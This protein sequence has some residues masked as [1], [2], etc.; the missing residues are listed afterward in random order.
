MWQQK[1][2]DMN[3][4]E[5]VEHISA[6]GDEG[7]PTAQVL[8]RLQPLPPVFQ[9]LRLVRGTDARGIL[10]IRQCFQTLVHKQHNVTAN[11]PFLPC[12]CYKGLGHLHLF[13]CQLS[14][15]F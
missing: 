15:R 13:S 4:D 7:S 10:R 3:T 1:E 8:F 14:A 11:P 6:M 2:T 9:E 5:T 12:N